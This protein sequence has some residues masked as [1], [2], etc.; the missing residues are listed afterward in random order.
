MK[1]GP[2]GSPLFFWPVAGFLVFW[3]LMYAGLVTFTF[4]F[5]TPEHWATLV[6]E[7][8]IRAEYAQYIGR[9]PGWVVVMTFAAAFTR[10]AGGIALL[11]RT[12]W[13]LP[14]YAV[15][16]CFVA[17]IMFRGFVLADVASVIR[18]SQVVLELA[19]LLISIFA[20]GYA[21]WLRENGFLK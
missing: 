13:A 15:S 18:S 14:L 2:Q 6:A 4:A 9:I 1:S 10:L 3:G 21:W 19:F 12:G 20:V 8:R 7:G 16:L 11:V 17:V 5:A